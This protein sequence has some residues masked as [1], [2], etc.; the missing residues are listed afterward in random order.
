MN[1]FD[2]FNIF[3]TSS[4]S[5]YKFLKSAN[6]SV[7]LKKSF[8]TWYFQNFFNPLIFSLTINISSS[9]LLVE[10]LIKAVNKIKNKIKDAKKKPYH[11]LFPNFSILIRCS[12]FFNISVLKS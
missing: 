12:N 7:E 5:K 2:F 8:S 11:N 6:F 3:F 1:N 10:F 9:I 4:S